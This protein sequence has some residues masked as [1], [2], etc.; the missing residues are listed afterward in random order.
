MKV[1]KWYTE[2]ECK[3]SIAE[4]AEKFG[5]GTLSVS[6]TSLFFKTLFGVI[7]LAKDQ[8]E[9]GEKEELHDIWE[10]IQSDIEEFGSMCFCFEVWNSDFKFIIVLD[11][12]NIAIGEYEGVYTPLKSVEYSTWIS[13]TPSCQMKM[14]K[15]G[16]INKI[17]LINNDV[18]VNGSVK[19]VTK[20]R[21]WIYDL[22]SIMPFEATAA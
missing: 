14:M 7:Y 8:C 6:D 5:T 12:D 11:H 13:L 9:T 20:P 1:L 21:G 18:I 4:F 10:N 19:L 17:E 15:G 2:Q 16:L 3:E 22:I